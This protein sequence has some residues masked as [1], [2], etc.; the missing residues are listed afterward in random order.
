MICF[1]REEIKVTHLLGITNQSK[2]HETISQSLLWFAMKHNQTIYNI[3]KMITLR[4]KGISSSNSNTRV[5]ISNSQQGVSRSKGR[6]RS[7]SL[8]ENWETCN[9]TYGDCSKQT[10]LCH[11]WIL[12]YKIINIAKSISE[13]KF[14]GLIWSCRIRNPIM[15]R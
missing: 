4:S 12:N 7:L 5:P 3:W 15:G 14:R 6:N 2:L 10:S 9:L 1:S 8:N 13:T 11:T